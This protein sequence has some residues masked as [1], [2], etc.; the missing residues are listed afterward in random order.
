MSL[1]LEYNLDL[2]SCDLQEISERPGLFHF[3]SV[4]FYYHHTPCSVLTASSKFFPACQS[5]NFVFLLPDLLMAGVF[6]LYL[7]H[8]IFQI[9]LP[10]RGFPSLHEF[11]TLPSSTLL[12]QSIIFNPFLLTKYLSLSEILI[13]FFSTR[14]G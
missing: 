3:C 8:Y 12:I 4:I 14:N 1:Y 11:S 6:S 7:F 9:A 2:F 5:L 10:Q 13:F